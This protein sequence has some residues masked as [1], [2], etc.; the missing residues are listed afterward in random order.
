MQVRVDSSESLTHIRRSAIAGL[1]RLRDELSR[2]TKS[3]TAI[4]EDSS[5]THYIRRTKQNHLT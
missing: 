1:R 5:V 2:D 4:L 3:S